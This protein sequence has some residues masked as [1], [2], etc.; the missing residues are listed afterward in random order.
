[1]EAKGASSVGTIPESINVCVA[2]CFIEIP[3]IPEEDDVRCGETEVVRVRP[4]CVI[5]F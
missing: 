1:M 3:Y 5:A 2:P 4:I